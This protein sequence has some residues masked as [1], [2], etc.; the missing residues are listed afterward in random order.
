MLECHRAQSRAVAGAKDLDRI[1]LELNDDPG[2]LEALLQLKLEIHSLNLNFS[3]WVNTHAGCAEALNSWLIRCLGDVPE[4]ML[5]APL[6]SVICSRWAQVIGRIKDK[7]V[8]D[9]TR[10]LY[11]SLNRAAGSRSL[12]LNSKQVQDKEMERKVKMFEKEEQRIHRAMQERERRLNMLPGKH[13]GALL[14]GRSV[15]RK[16]EIAKRVPLQESLRGVF[17]SL[18]RF[19]HDSM[20]AYEELLTCTKG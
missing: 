14:H 1:E 7:E 18:E 20:E 8:F 4:E 3:S 11:E 6:V 9:A 5:D 15:P 16:N 2:S 19:A 17:E 12:Y 13:N 10:E